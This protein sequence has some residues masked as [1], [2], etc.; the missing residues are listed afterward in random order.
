MTQSL[1]SWL[2][3]QPSDKH[4]HRRPAQKVHNAFTGKL[5]RKIKINKNVETLKCP[6]VL[7]K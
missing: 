7:D 6:S 4:V 5:V 2:F 1:F 3:I